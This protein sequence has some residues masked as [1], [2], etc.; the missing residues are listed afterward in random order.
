MSFAGFDQMLQHKTFL[1]PE[2]HH[3]GEDALHEAAPLLALRS[4]ARLPPNHGVSQRLLGSVVR[5]LDAFPP[6]KCPERLGHQVEVTARILETAFSVADQLLYIRDRQEKLGWGAKVVEQLSTDLRR[7]FPEMKGFSSRN[8]L[9]MRRFAQTW[10]DETIVKQL[11][12]LLPW[13]HNIRLIQKVAEPELRLWYLRKAVAHGWSRDILVLQI[14]SELH[15]REGAAPTNFDL[16]NDSMSTR[17][18]LFDKR[19]ENDRHRPFRRCRPI[20]RVI[21]EME[22]RG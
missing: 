20:P 21:Q 11:V 1:P 14:D 8:L 7:A 15:S 3:N 5:R 16:R 12:S 2:R 17:H 19:C 13:G 18:N 4:E 10:S 9:F 6:D 22:G